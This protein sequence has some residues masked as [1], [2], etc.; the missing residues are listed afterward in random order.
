MERQR[1]E[2]CPIDCT[3]GLGNIYRNG[4][5]TCCPKGKTYIYSYLEELVHS[6]VVEHALEHE[7]ICRGKPAEEK[8]EEGET[9]A[10]QQPPQA[11]GCE[12]TMSLRG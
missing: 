1:W 2:A 10:E 9:D 6:I 4:S 12:A 8:H 3:E 7:V 5:Q 11:S